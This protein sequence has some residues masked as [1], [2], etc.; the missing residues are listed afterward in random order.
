[1]SACLSLLATVK[2]VTSLSSGWRDTWLIFPF[3]LWNPLKRSIITVHVSRWAHCQ[4]FHADILWKWYGAG[5]SLPSLWSQSEINSKVTTIIHHQ[6]SVRLLSR[7]SITFEF[8]LNVTDETY[9]VYVYSWITSSGIKSL[10][11]TILR[12]NKIKFN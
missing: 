4:L 12:N 10:G 2:A 9:S 7:G 6:K 8:W 11:F 3:F 5:S 1:M